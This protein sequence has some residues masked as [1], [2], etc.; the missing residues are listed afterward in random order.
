M[1]EA[2]LSGRIRV[3]QYPEY[4]CH[5]GSFLQKHCIVYES[6]LEDGDTELY[7]HTLK[8]YQRVYKQLKKRF[9][10]LPTFYDSEFLAEH[11]DYFAIQKNGKQAKEEWVEFVC[12]SRSDFRKMKINQ[13]KE[14]VL[15]CQPDGV[16]IDF[17]RHFVYWEKI[18]QNFSIST[19]QKIPLSVL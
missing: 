10:L 19:N 6:F 9:L 18:Y 3:Y 12:P 2:I 15:H 5:R 11:P 17:I 1:R 14:L 8:R 13:L 4:D 16:S 7:S